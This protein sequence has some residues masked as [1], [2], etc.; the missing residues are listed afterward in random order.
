MP[1]PLELLIL[2][3]IMCLAFWV[4]GALGAEFRAVQQEPPPVAYWKLY[5]A[6]TPTPF[7]TVLPTHMRSMAVPTGVVPTPGPGTPVPTLRAYSFDVPSFPPGVMAVLRAIGLDGL[8]SEDSNVWLSYTET[9][10][11]TAT[12]TSTGTP[13]RTPTQTATST[14]TATPTITNTPT[15]PKPCAPILF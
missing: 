12:A 3:A 15:P 11:R 2:I 13:T 7:A 6:G 14:R 10:T 4:A 8:E 1:R 5:K 9:P